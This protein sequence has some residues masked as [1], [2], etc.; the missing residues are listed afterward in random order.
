M[1]CHQAPGTRSGRRRGRRPAYPL[2]HRGEAG[3]GLGRVLL[4][5]TPL[6]TSAAFRRLWAGQAL[7]GLGGQMTLVAVMAQVWGAT[8]STAWTGAVGLAQAVPLTGL[9]L[10]AGSL[11]DRVDRRRLY[12]LATGGQTVCSL[13]L[14]AQGLLLPRV[15]LVP[16]SPGGPH[17][18]LPPL[19]VAFVLALVALQSCCA[20]ASGPASATFVPALLPE[21]QVAAGLAL[22][23]ISF[24]SAMLAGP[25]LGGLIAAGPGVGVC[26]LADALSFL[27]ALYGAFGLPPMA[28]D[29]G[30]AARPGLGGIRDGLAF[31]ARTPAVRGALLTDLAST[32]LAMPVSVF[33]LVNAERFGGS[34]RTLGLFLTAMAVGGT[35]ASFVSGTFTRL[36]RPGPVMFGGATAWGVSLALF[37]LVPGRWA[38]LGFLALAG[39]ADTVSVVC[40]GTVVQTHTPAHLL[41]RLG[42]AEQIVGWAGPDIGNMRAGLV[43]EAT[44]GTVALVSGGLLCVG[45]VVLVAMGTTGMR[46]EPPAAGGPGG[47]AREAGKPGGAG[48]G[49]RRRGHRR[50]CMMCSPT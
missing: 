19:P 35:A 50:Q 37:A 7:S 4:D 49:V 24:Q 44:S 34:P 48:A 32:V 30:R 29:R 8:G 5:V 42:A 23:R 25:A 21:R 26:H 45:A 22:R 31:A 13:L 15:P 28:P 10:F 14:A 2:R 9:G 47:P 41:G 11:A 43:A 38:A 17:S 27:A 36:P 1:P 16:G 40:R 46:I 18:P 33:P 39:A 6:C 20:A 3:P 12:L